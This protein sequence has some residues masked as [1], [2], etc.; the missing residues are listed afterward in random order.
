M[1]ELVK[2]EG[3]I[4]EGMNSPEFINRMFFLL[5]EFNKDLVYGEYLAKCNGNG[6]QA[7]LEALELWKRVGI[8]KEERTYV[9]GFVN[10]VILTTIADSETQG[11]S[12]VRIMDGKT[13][14]GDEPF[15]ESFDKYDELPEAPAKW[16]EGN[17]CT[18]LIVFSKGNMIKI[19][20]TDNVTD[21]LNKLK[22][23]FSKGI[24]FIGYTESN[25]EAELHFEYR[26]NRYYEDWFRLSMDNLLDIISK[27]KFRE[28]TTK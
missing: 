12:I 26:K 18:Y 4:T 6:H 20:L 5:K 22:K 15:I 3:C 24:V 27:Y 9:N 23:E 14:F 11:K 16:I 25:V 8:G 2:V 28:L 13:P 10:I 19:G 21:R 17:Y 1:T 7:V